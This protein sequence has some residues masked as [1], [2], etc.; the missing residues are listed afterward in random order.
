MELR[1]GGESV[2]KGAG[3]AIK[4]TVGSWSS[5]KSEGGGMQ[6]GAGKANDGV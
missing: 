6:Q 4:K 2:Q 3:R 1:K 5:W